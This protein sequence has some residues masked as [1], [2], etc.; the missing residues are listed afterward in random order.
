[1][2]IAA[3]ISI[4]GVHHVA[5]VVVHP[6]KNTNRFYLQEVAITEELQKEAAFKTGASADASGEPSGA[7]PSGAIRTL[8]QKVF[9]VNSKPIPTRCELRHGIAGGY[10]G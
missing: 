8:L 3:P 7:A 9:A 2:T 6:D 4:A 5:V 1:M 10:L